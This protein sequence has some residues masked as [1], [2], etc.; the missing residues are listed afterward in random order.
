MLSFLLYSIQQMTK[1]GFFVSNAYEFISK[2][3]LQ[4]PVIILEKKKNKQMPV[5]W[6]Y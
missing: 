4:I 2:Y 1:S 6:R 3:L 5:H